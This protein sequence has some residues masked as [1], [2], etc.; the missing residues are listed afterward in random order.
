MLLQIV[1]LKLNR[2]PTV[3]VSDPEWSGQATTGA[4]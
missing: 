3:Q 1:K 2:I 4:Q